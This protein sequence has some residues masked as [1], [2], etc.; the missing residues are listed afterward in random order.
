MT[1]RDTALFES[2]GETVV[3]EVCNEGEEKNYYLSGLYTECDVKNGNGRTYPTSIVEREI[4]GKILPKVKAG[5]AFG[6]FGHPKTL[7]EMPSIDPSRIAHRIVEIQKE[8][9]NIFRGKS[10]LVPEGLGKVAIAMVKTGGVLSVSSRGVGR[11]NKQT[12]VVESSYNMF[13]YDVVLNPGMKKAN[14]TAVMENQEFFVN[15]IGVFTE[16]EWYKIEKDRSKMLDATF[17][18]A[19]LLSGLA[20]IARS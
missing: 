4:N 8:G 6:E 10:V 17:F 20:E 2:F 3:E 18:R 12:G 9:N 5:T 19:D 13:T 7:A 15:Q 16:E 1:E 14:Q 11:V